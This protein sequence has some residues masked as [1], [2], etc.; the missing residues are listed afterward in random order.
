MDQRDN[1]KNL[2][3]VVT[4]AEKPVI[5]ESRGKRGGKVIKEGTRIPGYWVAVSTSGKTLHGDFAKTIEKARR[6][7]ERFAEDMEPGDTLTMTKEDGDDLGH[8][9]M[10]D[11]DHGM[12]ELSP[13]FED[14]ISEVENESRSLSE[15]FGYKL[16]QVVAVLRE[17]SE[18][19][20]AHD[21]QKAYVL[22]AVA[23]NLSTVRA[24]AHVTEQDMIKSLNESD[25][26][27][28]TGFQAED[29]WEAVMEVL[30]SA[31]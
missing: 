3:N 31:L 24:S 30:N 20:L 23:E 8:S 5:T 22:H 29:I 11:V 17:A 28:E 19:M 4:S 26:K 16:S 2:I 7:A 18:E 21:Q 15:E 13:S 14:K 9:G 25:L 6:N 12:A 27:L 10:S 1:F